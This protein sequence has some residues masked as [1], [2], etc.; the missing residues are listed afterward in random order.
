MGDPETQAILPLL[1]AQCDLFEVLSSCATTS[2]S[3]T[4]GYS[5]DSGED[6]SE[7]EK[8]GKLRPCTVRFRD[9]LSACA[10]VCAAPGYPGTYEKGLEITGLEQV[11]RQ[12]AHVFHAGTCVAYSE[13]SQGRV[14]SVKSTGGRVRV[15]LCS[16]CTLY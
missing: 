7:K 5:R 9:D 3:S 4:D 6:S 16:C 8:G 1:H 15:S 12:T 13:E 10:V 14:K 11:C 2:T